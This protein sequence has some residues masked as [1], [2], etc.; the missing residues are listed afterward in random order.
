MKKYDRTKVRCRRSQ[1]VIQQLHHPE[2][3]L[4]NFRVSRVNVETIGEISEPLGHR[5]VDQCCVQEI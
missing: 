1:T 3:K 2:S 5:L 4:L